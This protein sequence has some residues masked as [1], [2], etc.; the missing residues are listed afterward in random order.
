MK[1]FSLAI[2]LICSFYGSS[3]DT[4]TTYFDEDWDPVKKAKH[5][6]F[7]RKSFYNSDN[8]YQVNDYYMSRQLQM[9]GTYLSEDIKYESGEFIYYYES[10]KVDHHGFYEKGKKVG[11]W[12]YYFKTGELDAEGNYVNNKKDGE[13]LYY[14]KNGKLRQKR[15][16]DYGEIQS[17]VSWDKNGAETDKPTIYDVVGVS[18][19]FIGGE[20]A[21]A[22]F[23]Q[24]EFNYPSKSREMGE[25][26][27]VYIRFVVTKKGT[28]KDAEI[29]KGV[30][31]LLDEEAIRVIEA[32]PKWK[33]GELDGKPVSVWYTIPIRCR[34]DDN[35][36]QKR[37]RRR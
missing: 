26:G 3:Q 13:W 29:V 37:R 8:T 21:M 10:G 22:T 6:A 4:L 34:L 1:N 31:P 19:E 23:I 24:K 35:S 11:V 14:H 7:Y 20:Q 33:P 5:A 12:K 28:I 2:F 27:T 16:Y 17:A 15:I 32:M 9:S 30:S 18:P 25:Q 36:K